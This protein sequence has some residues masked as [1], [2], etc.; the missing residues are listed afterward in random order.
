MKVK[1]SAENHQNELIFYPYNYCGS[2]GQVGYPVMSF[3]A[4]KK[5]T[6]WLGTEI[7]FLW[8]HI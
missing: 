1:V 6:E 8:E 5:Y 4:T 7:E 3:E 2:F